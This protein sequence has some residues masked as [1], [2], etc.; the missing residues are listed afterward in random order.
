MV[1]AREGRTGIYWPVVVSCTDLAALVLYWHD[2]RANIPQYGPR[3]RLVRLFFFVC[4]RY[5]VTLK[6]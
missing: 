6:H 4:V 1:T 5:L 3:T 2:P